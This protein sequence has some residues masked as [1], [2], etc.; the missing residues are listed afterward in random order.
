MKKH[1]DMSREQFEQWYFGEFCNTL[2]LVKH[3]DTGEYVLKSTINMLIGWQARG[4]VPVKMPEKAE[5]N[6]YISPEQAYAI[7]D[8][9]EECAEAIRQAGYPVEGDA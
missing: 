9:I 7:N 1:E 5:F 2:G 4:A 3:D 8:T 6:Q